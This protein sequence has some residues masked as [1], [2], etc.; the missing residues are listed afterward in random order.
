MPSSPVIEDLNILKYSRFS[1]I[2][3]VKELMVD[4]F[5]FDM[6]EEAFSKGVVKAV[7]EMVFETR[8]L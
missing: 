5:I 3:G 6:S 4:E 2:Q 8:K 1:L 7:L